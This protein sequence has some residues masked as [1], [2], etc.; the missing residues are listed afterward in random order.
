MRGIATRKDPT[1][2]APNSL[3]HWNS[4]SVS[5]DGIGF[6]P[7]SVPVQALAECPAGNSC[8]SALCGLAKI[9]RV[10]LAAAQAG[11]RQPSVS[12]LPQCGQSDRRSRL[13]PPQ[14]AQT[15]RGRASPRRRGR[16]IRDDCAGARF[17]FFEPRHHQAEPR[18]RARRGRRRAGAAGPDA[19]S[20]TGDKGG[21]GAASP[22]RDGGAPRPRAAPRA[23]P[24]PAARWVSR[25][26]GFSPPAARSLEPVERRRANMD[27]AENLCEIRMGH[28]P[29]CPLDRFRRGRARRPQA[30][31]ARNGPPESQDR[32][33][34]PAPGRQC[35]T[36]A[37]ISIA[38][39]G[40]AQLVEDD[41]P[42]MTGAVGAMIRRLLARASPCGFPAAVARLEVEQAHNTHARSGAT[43]RHA[44]PAAARCPGRQCE[45]TGSAARAVR[46]THLGAVEHCGEEFFAAVSSPSSC[47]AW[48]ESSRVNG[49]SAR[50]ASALRAKRRA[51]CGSPAATAT[52]P[53]VS[54]R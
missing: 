48:A 3:W 22:A 53:C 9:G 11:V 40:A 30:A 28:R 50:S 20:G 25:A 52:I 13:S 32:A 39:R 36:S 44:R 35:Q 29:P 38:E 31:A 27:R 1:R 41:T 18:G 2:S 26:A 14:S 42:V 5:R 15:Q 4:I 23:R 33:S 19:G 6:S 47:A 21:G 49:G 46:E 7:K 54:A 12:K 24:P 45:G 17:G 8:S 10:L 51:S 37:A 43:T 16:A 34:A